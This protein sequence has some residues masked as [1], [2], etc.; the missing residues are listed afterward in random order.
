MTTSGYE[1]HPLLDPSLP[2]NNPEVLRH[3]YRRFLKIKESQ[4]AYNDFLNLVFHP[5]GEKRPLQANLTTAAYYLN[6]A[7]SF[8]GELL[9]MVPQ[10]ARGHLTPLPVV[11]G[12]PDILELLTLIFESRD[13]RAAF[14]AQRKLYL[15]KLFFDVDHYWEVQRGNEHKEFF[16][17]LLQREIFSRT[18]G[19][20]KIE[21]CYAIG[22]DG[23]SMEYSV[24]PNGTNQECWSFDL[25]EIDYVRAGRPVKFNIYYYSCRFK[26]EVIPYQYSRGS[27]HYQ[28]TPTEIW[29]GLSKR[30]S[31][32]IV[33][34]MIRKG[35]SDPRWIEDLIGAMFIV[36]N[37]Y[38]VESL[39]ESL[40]DALGGIFR[41]RNVVD[42]LTSRKDQSRLNPWSGQ[43]YE[44]YKA[45]VDILYN[46]PR[47]KLPMPYFF[48]A[49]IQMYTLESYL[50]TIHS[51]HYASHQA[52]KRRQFL[53]GLVPFLFPEKIYGQELARALAQEAAAPEK[54]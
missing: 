24:G 36:E 45:D 5:I 34:K 39:K 11:M 17:S 37:L 50:R 2:E 12:C 10:E 29:P 9:L 6:E 48:T 51:S 43:G 54:P 22:P 21:I 38:E 33:A 40:F 46:P 26:R 23:E 8:I 35:E 44:V 15:S 42:T 49:E 20:K 32:S 4:E 7:V 27:E 25:R 19:R 28:L 53:G 30:R 14:E 52:L 16:E 13:T 1:S 3:L 41:V 47:Q 18:V 31:A